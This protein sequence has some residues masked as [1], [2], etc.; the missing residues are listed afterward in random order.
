MKGAGL[1]DDVRLRGQQA[2]AGRG[3][4]ASEAEDR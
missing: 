3:T 2:S 1:K 4:A